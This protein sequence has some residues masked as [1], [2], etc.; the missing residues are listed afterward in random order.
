MWAKYRSFQANP[1][2]AQ[3]VALAEQE[4]DRKDIEQILSRM[5]ERARRTSAQLSSNLRLRNRTPCA[6]YLRQIELE[7][8][9][10]KMHTGQEPFYELFQLLEAKKGSA[11]EGGAN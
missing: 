2:E 11:A 7:N 3:L 5:I 8:E 6:G 4:R 1:T 9:F 10:I